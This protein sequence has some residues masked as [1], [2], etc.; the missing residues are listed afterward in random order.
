MYPA[1][2]EKTKA[3]LPR[4]L[5]DRSLDKYDSQKAV[6]F[7]RANPE[8]ANKIDRIQIGLRSEKQSDFARRMSAGEYGSLD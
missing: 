1:R 7:L 5:R 6:D 3:Q 2:G 8:I 4:E